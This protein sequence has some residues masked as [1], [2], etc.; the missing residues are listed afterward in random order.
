[1]TTERRRYFRIKERALIKYRVIQEDMLVEERKFIFLNEIK[2]ENLH[3]ALL[4]I[5]LRLHDLVAAVRGES[6][7][8]AEALDLINRKLTLLER[9]VS[10]ESSHLG[11][12]EYH[13]HEPT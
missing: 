8:V 7:L 6:K 12:S 9:V 11:G 3:A 13:E 2:V 4:G 5:D 10:L 1:M